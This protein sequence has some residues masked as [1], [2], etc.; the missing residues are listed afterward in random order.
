M[1]LRSLALLVLCSVPL[2][3]RSSGASMHEVPCICGQPAADF[4]GCAH[5]ACVKGQRNPDNP[6]CVCGS[7]TIPK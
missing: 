1:K 3:C 7:L 4:E 6:D 2:A 5:E